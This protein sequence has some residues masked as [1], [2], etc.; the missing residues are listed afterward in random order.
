MDPTY[1]RSSSFRSLM[2]IIS[3]VIADDAK[4]LV[5]ILI[6]LSLKICV[7]ILFYN[8][9]DLL[10][11]VNQFRKRNKKNIW[12]VFV[13]VLLGAMT[14]GK[15]QIIIIFLLS[16]KKKARKNK[17]IHINQ[18]CVLVQFDKRPFIKNYDNEILRKEISYQQ[19]NIQTKNTTGSKR[20]IT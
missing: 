6:N 10:S 7:V 9:A 3:T 8:T 15:K 16:F 13:Q 4:C 2:K 18:R 11:I 19:T 20:E 5:F 14:L 17:Q 1:Q 12:R